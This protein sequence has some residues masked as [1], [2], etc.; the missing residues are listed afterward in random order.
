MQLNQKAIT[1]KIPSLGKFGLC[2]L[3]IVEFYE[4]DNRPT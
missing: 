2:F 1:D 4:L 3:T